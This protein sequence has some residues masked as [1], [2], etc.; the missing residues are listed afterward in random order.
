MVRKRGGPRTEAGRRR[1]KW[2]ALSHGILSK[3][4]V[5][6]SGLLSEDKE[7]FT[8]LLKALIRDLQPE[9]TL[10]QILVE[11]IAVAYWRLRRVLKCEI[12]EIS[13]QRFSR[14]FQQAS[15]TSEVARDASNGQ[16]AFNQ[17][18]QTISGAGK[19]IDI[20]TKVKGSVEHLGYLS[21]ETYEELLRHFSEEGHIG[22][23]LSIIRKRGVP[24]VSAKAPTT[25]DDRVETAEIKANVLRLISEEFKL[26]RG[27]QGISQDS[28][29]FVIRA[30]DRTLSIPS[31]E[32]A[33][34][35]LR[36]ETTTERQFYRAIDQLERLQRRRRGEQIPAPLRV[37][38]TRE[39]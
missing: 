29:Q 13:I 21:E 17:L 15:G 18:A 14:I 22:W 36:Y 20:L 38:L 2:N 1:S 31:K 11:K 24:V 39:E 26:L 27:I 7:E 25:K 10:E 4:I 34:R 28:Q 5:I 37:D 12:G 30:N 19:L 23:K 8:S 33:D 6:S 16:A 35:T 3:E 32:S 9:G